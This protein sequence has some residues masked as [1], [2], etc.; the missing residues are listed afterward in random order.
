MRSYLEKTTLKKLIPGTNIVEQ[1]LAEEVEVYGCK[2]FWTM[3]LEPSVFGIM[4]ASAECQSPWNFNILK[5][6]RWFWKII[7]DNF[8]YHF[9][10]H[11]YVDHSGMNNNYS[12]CI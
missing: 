3:D 7:I 12:V 1:I 9:F 4:F 5:V 8:G 6:S 10:E 2:M 11:L